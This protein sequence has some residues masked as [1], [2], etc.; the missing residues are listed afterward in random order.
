M[1]KFFSNGTWRPR[2]A[3]IAETSTPVGEH[4]LVCEAAIQTDDCGILMLHMGE[5]GDAYRPWHLACFRKA[6]GIERIEA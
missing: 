4:C 2:S 3:E 6:L 5:H 1:M